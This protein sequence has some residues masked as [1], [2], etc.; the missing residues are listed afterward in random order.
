M[1][2][3]PILFV[4]SVAFLVAVTAAASEPALPEGLGTASTPALPEGLSSS[5]PSLPAGLESGALSKSGEQPTPAKRPGGTVNRT[6]R[7]FA[8]VRAGVWTGGNPVEPDLPIAE[9]RLQLDGSAHYRRL[10]AQAT[11]D[12]VGDAIADSQRLDLREGKGPI[13]LRELWLSAPLGGW[14]DLKA[15]RQ[16]STWGTGDYLFI[17]DLFPKDWRS[18]FLGR[19]D[20]YLK[21]PADAVRLSGYSNLLNAEVVFT[22]RF[23]P[24]RF[25]EGNRIS[26]FDAGTGEIAGESAVINPSIPDGGEVALRVY[27]LFGDA[28]VAG[29]FYD[30]Y[31]K[32]P[33]GRNLSGRPIFPELRIFG[34]SVRKPLFGGIAHAEI[35]HYDSLDDADGSNP[36]V[37][38]SELRILAGYER[39]LGHELTGSVQWYV[40]RMQ[41]YSAYVDSVPEGSTKSDR[42]RHVLTLRLTKSLMMQDLV[43]SLFAFYSPTDDDA[44]LRPT[45]KYSINDHW[46][47]SA[48]GNF[49]F[50]KSESTFF[51]Q[52]E[53]N[54]N[55]YSSLRFSY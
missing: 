40:E 20:E 24:D 18:F 37:R 34:A 9:A 54:T 27:R 25:I 26:Y 49:F 29:Y 8:E 13:D 21:A 31:W 15:G 7:G 32:S 41:D 6:L 33:A 22:P 2:F 50:G 5:E 43:L 46:D 42:T 16:V 45:I 44:Y 30:G 52:F 14:G 23:A 11:V 17:N 35:G 55:V 39:E 38:N 48:G 47:V 10:S 53:K 12:F 28:E 4:F 51:G 19:D 36:A 1:R 3:P